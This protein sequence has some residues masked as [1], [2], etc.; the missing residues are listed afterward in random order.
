MR[1]FRGALQS[2]G[3]KQASNPRLT[4]S[5]PSGKAFWDSETVN[6]SLKPRAYKCFQDAGE[7]W[8]ADSIIDV[9]PHRLPPLWT[10]VH[11]LTVPLSSSLVSCLHSSSRSNYKFSSAPP[12]SSVLVLNLWIS[13]PLGVLSRGSPKTLENT[14]VYLHYDS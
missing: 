2:F 11:I 6:M 1:L 5:Q 7:W 12:P 4:Q 10:T 14:D 13:T 3:F 9:S 8:F